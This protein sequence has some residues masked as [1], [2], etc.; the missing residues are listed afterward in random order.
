MRIRRHRKASDTIWSN[1]IKIHSFMFLWSICQTCSLSCCSSLAIVLIAHTHFGVHNKF[2]VEC[3][4][5]SKNVLKRK[6]HMNSF[7]HW[8][9]NACYDSHKSESLVAQ[10]KKNGMLL[11][12]IGLFPSTKWNVWTMVEGSHSEYGHKICTIL[13]LFAIKCG[14]FYANY[15]VLFGRCWYETMRRIL[16]ETYIF[17]SLS[18]CCIKFVL[19]PVLVD[20]SFECIS[21]SCVVWLGF[22]AQS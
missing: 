8:T 5:T 14:K 15:F 6:I 18:L 19:I 20:D 10:R 1:S 2:W 7:K 13:F 11:A 22:E 17:F 3:Y 12:L 4:S 9:L 16:T 21:S